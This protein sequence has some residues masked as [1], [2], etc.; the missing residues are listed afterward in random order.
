MG[1]E[2]HV[3]G[4]RTECMTNWAGSSPSLYVAHKLMWDHT[5]NVGAILDDYCQKSFGPAAG[6]MRR[7]IDLMDKDRLRRRLP[8]RLDL[9]HGAGVQRGGPRSGPRGP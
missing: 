3:A 7:Y 6:P 1:H 8:H 5:A 9:G 2:L 4:W